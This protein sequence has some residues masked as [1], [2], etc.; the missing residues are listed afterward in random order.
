M[1]RLPVMTTRF[2]RAILLIQS[3]VGPSILSA[4]TDGLMLKPVLNISGNT[5]TS[6]LLMPRMRSS[7][8]DRLAALSSQ[9]RSAWIILRVRDDIGAN[10]LN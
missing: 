2:S 4:N 5:I 10:Y 9:W 8:M 7:N 3:T 6:V 1:I